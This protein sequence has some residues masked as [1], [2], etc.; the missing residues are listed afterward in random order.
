MTINKFITAGLA[1]LAFSTSSHAALLANSNSAA[2][3]A[4]TDYSVAGAVSF[5]LA[6]ANFT[7]TTLNFV[8][9]EADLAGAAAADEAFEVQFGIAERVQI[10][11]ALQEPGEVGGRREQRFLQRPRIEGVAAEVV[12]AFKA[13]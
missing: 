12:H 13:R 5:D 9:E 2:G 3:N 10:L 4:V 6:L 8:L 11:A 7:G 1:A